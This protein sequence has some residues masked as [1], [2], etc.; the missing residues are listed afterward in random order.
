MAAAV[1]DGDIMRFFFD[2]RR[3]SN[4]TDITVASVISLIKRLSKLS[5]LVSELT[6][7]ELQHLMVEIGTFGLYHRGLVEDLL[8]QR[9]NDEPK[10]LMIWAR[11]M[12]SED[13][14]LC[15]FYAQHYDPREI[16]ELKSDKA[17]ERIDRLPHFARAYAMGERYYSAFG[18]AI[19]ENSA[20]FRYLDE[21]SKAMEPDSKE[22]HD[23][24]GT[25]KL[26]KEA[27]SA[28]NPEAQTG[29]VYY[30]NNFEK[31]HDTV[32]D[33]ISKRYVIGPHFNG[34]HSFECYGYGSIHELIVYQI[35]TIEYAQKVLQ[36]AVNAFIGIERQIESKQMDRF[37]Y[38]N[39]RRSIGNDGVC[40]ISWKKTELVQHTQFLMDTLKKI[41][42]EFGITGLKMINDYS[43]RLNN[44]DITVFILTY[45]ENAELKIKKSPC[46][47]IEYYP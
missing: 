17:F 18:L 20:L 16:A 44:K 3:M 19:G 15:A 6:D 40:E 2:C 34:V 12:N 22:D 35:K 25:I 28:G 24:T 11:F 8:C 29:L 43:I 46:Y 27:A 47:Y 45:L 39:E 7:L 26:L 42:E 14:N 37:Y 21:C 1:G 23:L 30:L 33:L 10:G 13:G 31:E 4:F 5:F 36:S 38:D 32:M 9:I 41:I